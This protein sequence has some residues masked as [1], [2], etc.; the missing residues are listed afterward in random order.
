MK[1]GHTVQETY[2]KWIDLMNTLLK[3]IDISNLSLPLFKQKYDTSWPKHARV[4]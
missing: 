1:I 2:F 4:S 3:P